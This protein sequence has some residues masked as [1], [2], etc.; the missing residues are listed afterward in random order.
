MK[1]SA[2]MIIPR[3]GDP[4]VRIDHGA[5][6]QYACDHHGIIVALVKADDGERIDWI[7]RHQVIFIQAVANSRPSSSEAPWDVRAFIDELIGS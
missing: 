4:V 5:A 6:M 2:Y 7:A 3:C 1:A